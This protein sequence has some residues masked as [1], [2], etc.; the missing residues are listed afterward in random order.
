M[1]V[2][3]VGYHNFNWSAL[4]EPTDLIFDPDK[5]KL[6]L[7]RNSFKFL[8]LM[9]A[10]NVAQIRLRGTDTGNLLTVLR[11]KEDAECGDARD[12]LFALQGLLSDPDI[13]IDFS[14][15]SSWST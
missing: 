8:P 14:K 2:C 15:P 6:W 9:R 4:E 3:V 1:V 11:Q 7:W 5:R 12:K 13:E 10:D